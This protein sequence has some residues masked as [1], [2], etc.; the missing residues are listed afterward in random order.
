MI[1]VTW[2]QFR[3]QTVL[4]AAFLAV[5]A[6]VFAVTGARLAALYGSSGLAACHGTA[7][8]SLASKFLFQARTDT[9]IKSVYQAGTVVVYA[10]PAVIGVF[11]GA[12]LLTREIEAGTFRL[13]WS[14]SVTRTRWLIAKLGLIG[15]SAIVAAGL[16]SLI[17]S[18]WAAP[19]DHAALLAGS[20]SVP[21]R[22]TPT[23][24]GARGVVPLG[25]AAFAFALGVTAGLLIRRTVAAMAATLAVFAAAEVAMVEW[26]RPHL[27]APVRASLPLNVRNLDELEITNNN[28]MMVQ[29]SASR[30]GAW[31]L[32]NQ[33][34]TP[35]GHVFTGPPTHACVSQA[36]SFQAC[37]ASVAGLHLR[38]L[39][40][41]QPASRFWAL[42]GIET[43]IFAAAALAL[44]GFC[45]WWVSRRRLS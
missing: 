20:S 10:V 16:L 27:L 41:Y 15:A 33:S 5:V 3:A 2:R 1:W 38:Q 24:Y 4:T 21:A 25:Y 6:V 31:I 26:I 11:W 30:P 12:P 37:Q 14:Q 7:C 8:G 28:K 13:A 45:F 34:V 9:V 19:V 18:W 39:L 36:A 17:V 40:T 42:Q 43:A 32:S 22:I 35:A 44:A 23:I 29:A